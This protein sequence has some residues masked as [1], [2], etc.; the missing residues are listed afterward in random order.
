[1]K[2]VT[3]HYVKNFEKKF[4]YFRFL[5]FKNFKKQLDFF[6]MN[7]KIISHKEFID[8]IEGK[9][10]PL[11][12]SILLTFDDGV[13]DHYKFVFKELKRR[14]IFGIFFVSTAPIEKKFFLNVHKIHLLV[15]KI[16]GNILIDQLKSLIKPEMIDKKK[17]LLFKKRAYSTQ[18]DHDSVK[19]FKQTL[20]Y[21]I[22]NKYKTKILDILIKKNKVDLK[23]RNFYLSLEHLKEMKN[24]GMI[25][26]SHTFS[27]EV[28]SNLSPKEQK[29]EINR[30]ISLLKKKLGKNNISTFC[31]PYGERY[32][33]NNHTL[34]IL[35]E[36]KVKASFI[37]KSKN[38]SCNKLLS[39]K[40]EIPRYD[41]NEFPFG[42][43]KKIIY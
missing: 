34:K 21:F 39:R 36:L 16:K 7:K 41:C 20:N 10:I 28:L 8:I 14:K 30:S 3:Y 37:V 26:G 42:S 43:I 17:K 29:K 24:N 6:E 9:M 38:V 2:V 25:I 12:N 33:Y 31:F 19:N 23:V 22:L 5:E 15:G 35:K 32:T 27:H 13:L 18:D 1:M 40:L 11:K 4:K